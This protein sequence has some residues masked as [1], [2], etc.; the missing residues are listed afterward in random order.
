VTNPDRQ[1]FAS[2]F[3]IRAPEVLTEAVERAAEQHMTSSSEYI[4]QAILDR[5]RS[6]NLAPR[7]ASVGV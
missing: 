6:D 7:S 3:R 5:L 4:R 2:C 1:R